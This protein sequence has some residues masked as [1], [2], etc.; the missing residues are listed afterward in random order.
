MAF[1]SLHGSDTDRA[2]DDKS[3]RVDNKVANARMA[4]RDERLSKLDCPRKDD[5]THHNDLVVSVITNSKCQTG[6]AENSEML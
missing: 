3:D 5:K 6:C 4:S 2:R 1:E